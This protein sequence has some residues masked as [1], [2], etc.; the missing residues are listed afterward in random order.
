MIALR[1]PPEIEDRLAALARRTGRSTDDYARDAIL[2]H[3]KDI[4]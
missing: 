4:E 2:D 1:L 3:L